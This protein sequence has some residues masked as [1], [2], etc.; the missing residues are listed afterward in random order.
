MV[1]TCAG[2]NVCITAY[3]SSKTLDC[4]PLQ[5]CYF[6]L[7]PIELTFWFHSTISSESWGSEDSLLGSL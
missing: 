7:P 2:K 6:A 1:Q 3:I 5:D 4:H